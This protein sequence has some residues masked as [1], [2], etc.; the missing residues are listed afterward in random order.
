MEVLK[1]GVRDGGGG[2]AQEQPDSGDDSEGSDEC[3]SS[4]VSDDCCA[5]VASPNSD[6]FCSVVGLVVVGPNFNALSKNAN[7]ELQVK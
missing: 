4:W 1:S 6:P 3:G 5:P 2:P 7:C